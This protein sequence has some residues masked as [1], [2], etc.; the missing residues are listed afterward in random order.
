MKG[1]NSAIWVDI[2]CPNCN[3]KSESSGMMMADRFGIC[4]VV[5]G[6]GWSATYKE[7]K[8]FDKNIKKHIFAKQSQPVPNGDEI[9]EARDA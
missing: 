4:C 3:Q 6:C 9:R 1:K 2:I 5:D 7:M 8:E